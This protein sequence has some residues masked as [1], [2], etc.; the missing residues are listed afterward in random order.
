MQ[1]LSEKRF[2]NSLHSETL[3]NSFKTLKE[4]HSNTVLIL[5]QSIESHKQ[6]ELTF[7]GAVKEEQKPHSHADSFR[8][9]CI[10]RGCDMESGSGPVMEMHFRPLTTRITPATSG[11]SRPALEGEWPD[12][13]WTGAWLKVSF[14]LIQIGYSLAFLAQY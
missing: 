5:S 9:R 11:I 8:P 3:R 10:G 4:T 2:E 1:P 12:M 6:V 13:S 7:W 14:E